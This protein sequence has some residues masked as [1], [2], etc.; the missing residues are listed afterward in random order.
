M[1]NTWRQFNKNVLVRIAGYN[2]IHILIRIGIGAVMSKILAVF[3][4]PAGLGVLAN[5]RNFV[6]GLQ[7][8]S[9]MG[10][11]NGLVR[12]ASNYREELPLLKKFYS[13]GWRLCIVAS[14]VLAI[15]VYFMAGVLDNYL[16]ESEESYAFVFR[17]M[18]VALP[19]YVVFVFVSSLLQGFEWYRKYITLNILINVAVFA[20]S[21]TLIYNYNLQGA[22]LA[23]VLSPIVQ[24][25]IAVGLWLRYRSK[26]PLFSSIAGDFDIYTLKPLLSYG[27]MALVSALLIPLVHI[28]V[29][30]HLIDTVNEEAAGYWEGIQRISSYY[31]LFVTSLIGLYVL[32]KLSKD[33]SALNYRLTIGHFYKTMFIPVVLG[34]LAIFLTRELLVSM[35]FTN[36]FTGMLPLFK[37]QLAGDF[38]KIITTVLAF[39]FIAIN[40][41]RRYVIAEVLSLT[42]MLI[43]SFVLIEMYGTMGVV[44]AHFYSYLVYLMALIILLRR[45]LNWSNGR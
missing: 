26:L 6:Q 2:S 15:V 39:R 40:D 20:V 4:G 7:T 8:F 45:E 5:L 24:C 41:L 33:D 38:V 35:L 25:L 10:L 1:R 3:I 44:M 11:E 32:P 23:I 28:L 18:A 13:T 21:A 36:E 9:I 34:L 43:A 17:V 14:L 30:Q 19:F 12:Y 22:L 27:A 31:M 42:A 29:R 16:I 37:W